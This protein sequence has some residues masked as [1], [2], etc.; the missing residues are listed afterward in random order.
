MT[1][2]GVLWNPGLYLLMLGWEKNIVD[3]G[4][5]LEAERQEKLLAERRANGEFDS[6]DTS[7]E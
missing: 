6:V 7:S 5:A 2:Q 3:A 1:A 4:M